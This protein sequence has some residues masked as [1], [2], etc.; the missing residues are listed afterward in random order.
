M[1][2]DCV[3]PPATPATGLRDKPGGSRL[4]GVIRLTNLG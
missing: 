4:M 2:S 3:P 1:S